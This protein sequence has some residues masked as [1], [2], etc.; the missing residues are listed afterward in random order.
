MEK[1]EETDLCVL[2]A[3]VNGNVSPDCLG[4]EKMGRCFLLR[5]ENDEKKR[6]SRRALVWVDSYLHCVWR[7]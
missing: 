6:R 7:Y 2:D 4:P 5:E 3:V 1:C